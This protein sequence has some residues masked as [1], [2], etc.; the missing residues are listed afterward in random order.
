MKAAATNA[1]TC[2]R[3]MRAGGSF[4]PVQISRA[5]GTSTSGNATRAGLRQRAA[6]GLNAATNVSRYNPS[7]TTHSSGTAAMSVDTYVVTASS[8]LDGTNASITHLAR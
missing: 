2:G 1:A 4:A 5:S 6:R 7:G 8:R 3:N